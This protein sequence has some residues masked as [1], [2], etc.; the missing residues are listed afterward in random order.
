LDE[1]A[2]D[3]FHGAPDEIARLG[4]AIARNLDPAAPAVEDASTSLSEK[5]RAFADVLRKAKRP[6]VISGTG[7][8]TKSV[9]E[10]AANVAKALKSEHKALSLVV[11]DCNSMGLA[12]FSGTS[13]EEATQVL[14]SGAAE[15]VVILENELYRHAGKGM[16]DRLLGHAKHVVVIDHT[17][18]PIAARADLLL[19]A[20]SFAES[21]GTYINNEGRAQRFFAAMLASGA[22]RDGWQWLRDAGA[23]N[24]QHIDEIVA[25]LAAG[26][27][28]LQ[29]VDN[30]APNAAFRIA[31][32]KI[33]RQSHR[34]SGRTAMRA[35]IAVSEPKQE[36]DPESALAF[37]MEGA[38]V[39]LP[40]SL[41]SSSW[42]P[43]WN[44]NQSIVKFQAEVG[45]HLKG[46]D[47]GIRLFKSSGA[48]EWF[49]E[50]PRS[51]SGDSG[52]WLI[53]PQYAIFG[54]E[55]LSS[56]SPAVAERVGAFCVL[57]NPRDL[58]NLD[59]SSGDRLELQFDDRTTVAE[60]RSDLGV[61]L[62]VAAVAFGFPGSDAIEWL[63]R[64]PI[65]KGARAV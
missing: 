42:A 13:L 63:T 52:S 27:P 35:N 11:P 38:A 1:L 43:A 56:G 39:Q 31:G 28:E 15:T 65:R 46:G 41:M 33:P 30:A 18:Y 9:V 51:A 49:S 8:L 61:P 64:I 7:C 58:A 24:W 2:S 6:L 36:V 16:V 60:A 40:P 19:P 10:A 23:G 25:A 34:Y 48:L 53:V 26:I 12:L 54:S 4:F 14:E 57:L 50:V 17:R 32:M 37:S 59:A 5:A 44:S 55:P 62:G 29:G 47:P 20:T 3:L 45:G 22:M 21:E